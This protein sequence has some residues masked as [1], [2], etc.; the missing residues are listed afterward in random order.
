MFFPRSAKLALASERVCNMFFVDFFVSPNMSEKTF[1]A[2]GLL[3]ILKCNSDEQGVLVQ[4]PARLSSPKTGGNFITTPVTR[5]NRKVQ[6]EPR[7]LH[8]NKD[9]ER[10]LFERQLLLAGLPAWGLLALGLMMCF[11]VMTTNRNLLKHLDNKSWLACL[12]TVWLLSGNLK[13]IHYW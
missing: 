4:H 5:S 10:F 9:M 13:E 12:A 11:P 3:L 1:W 6:E 8:F 7:S 2:A